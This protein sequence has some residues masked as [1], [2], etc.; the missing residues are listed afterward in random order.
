MVEMLASTRTAANRT[1]S[2]L[3]KYIRKLPVPSVFQSRRVIRRGT[4]RAAAARAIRGVVTVKRTAPT[5]SGCM[6]VDP[7]LFATVEVPQKKQ[8]LK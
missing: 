4:P 2:V 6:E 5:I 1:S 3:R 7:S 8:I